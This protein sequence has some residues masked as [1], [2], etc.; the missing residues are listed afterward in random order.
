MFIDELVLDLINEVDKRKVAEIK[1][2]IEENGY[3]GTPI[4]YTECML[5][6][7]SHRIAALRELE[8]V[9]FTAI[10]LTVEV[11][12]WLEENEAD[13]SEIQYDEI[14]EM[15]EQEIRKYFEI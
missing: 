10:D 1:K 12:A 2:S 3:I 4:F 14:N 5:L 6:T 11:N 13:Y 7:G 15:N 9:E 8:D